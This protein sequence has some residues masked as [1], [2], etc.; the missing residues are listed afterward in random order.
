MGSC[1]RRKATLIDAQ[2]YLESAR[3]WEAEGAVQDYEARWSALV[4]A[5]VDALQ[6]GAEGGVADRIVG[7]QH[8]VDPAFVA[9][10]SES[11]VGG[12][13]FRRGRSRS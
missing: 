2:T 3:G 1:A 6:G 10:S 13:G 4:G 8:A 11:S 5:V 9:D 7:H 12:W